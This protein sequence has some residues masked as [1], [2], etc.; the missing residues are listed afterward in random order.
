MNSPV[1]L[2]PLLAG[3]AVLALCGCGLITSDR[4]I[5]NHQ[6]HNFQAA[7]TNANW[8]KARTFLT[9][10]VRYYPLDSKQ[11][12]AIDQ[13]LQPIQAAEART[14]FLI[15]VTKLIEIAPGQYLALVNFQIQMS[16]T[17][18]SSLSTWPGSILWVRQ[19][20]GT[21]RV[22]EVK[23]LGAHQSSRS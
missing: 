14:G 22:A 15:D 16:S 21:W 10:E 23:D 1:L 7:M 20:N 11:P 17:G 2:R 12:V 5:V 9:K 19:P 4:R 18:G 3:L 6:L 8:E 13:W